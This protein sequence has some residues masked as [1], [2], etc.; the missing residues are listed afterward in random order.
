M[1]S[2]PLDIIKFLLIYRYL[3]NTY[4]FKKETNNFR[5]FPYISRPLKP[6]FPMPKEKDLLLATHK[7][8]SCYGRTSLVSAPI[9]NIDRAAPIRF[10]IKNKSPQKRTC[11][12]YS[13]ATRRCNYTSKKKNKRQKTPPKNDIPPKQTIFVG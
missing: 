4:W 6:I 1:V 8:C 9:Y 11:H 5:P 2:I 12:P 7:T 10:K 13:Q 3:Q